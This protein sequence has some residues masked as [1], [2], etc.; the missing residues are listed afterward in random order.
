MS[1]RYWSEAAKERRDPAGVFYYWSGERP[2]NPNAPQ[3]W[4][5]GEITVE[6]TDRAN[7]YCT[8]AASA[9]R[10]WLPTNP[11]PS[12]T[13]TKSRFFSTVGSKQPAPTLNYY[14]CPSTANSSDSTPSNSGT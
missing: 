7:G 13:P 10:S 14:V 2:R 4:G 3:L 1:V 11:P 5:T 12:P 9:V 8:R 6:S